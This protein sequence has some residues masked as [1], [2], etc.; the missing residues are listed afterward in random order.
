[1]KLVKLHIIP[2]KT[3]KLFNS[4]RSSCCPYPKSKCSD[5]LLTENYINLIADVTNTKVLELRSK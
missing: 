1:M 5:N 4:I 2:I 3:M